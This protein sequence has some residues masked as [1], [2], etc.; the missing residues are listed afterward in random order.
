MGWSA[1]FS[2]ARSHPGTQD[3][4]HAV[5]EQLD[6]PVAVGSAIPVMYV[7][8]DSTGVPVV[9]KETARRAGV[10]WS[11]ATASNPLTGIA[12]VV[13]ALSRG[14]QSTGNGTGSDPSSYH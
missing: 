12:I 13:L 2:A 9:R 11:A 10:F 6:L 1:Q 8:I 7:Q 4:Y 3:L 14:N 5:K